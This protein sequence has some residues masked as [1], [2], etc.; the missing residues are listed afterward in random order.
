MP[1]T[2][3]DIIVISVML[4]SGILAMVRGFLREVLSILSWVAAAA[5]TVIFY[6]QTLPLVQHYISQEMA[7]T[8]TTVA[9][10]FLGTLLIASIITA[11]ISDLVLD[12][13]IGALDRTLGFAFGLARGLL[14]MVVAF[15]FFNWLV[16]EKGQ[17]T[18][19]LDAKSRPT[20][21]SVGNWLIA[22]LPEDPEN[23]ILNKLKKP[24]S[25][26]EGNEASVPTIPAGGQGASTTGA[27]AGSAPDTAPGGYRGSDQRGLDQ[28]MESTR[29]NGQ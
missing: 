22:Q 1:V 9:V 3:L 12:S 19:V 16:P 17:P 21:Q 10:L 2:L 20:L 5:V 11:R 7:A 14:L 24:S 26:S 28:L 8:A 4:I 6:K 13:R 25:P 15:L 29:G 18:W 27:A 23:T